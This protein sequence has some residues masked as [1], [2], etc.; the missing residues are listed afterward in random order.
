MKQVELSRLHHYPERGF[1]LHRNK[2]LAPV[3]FVFKA[4]QI[5]DV[6]IIELKHQRAIFNNHYGN[7]VL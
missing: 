2:K 6:K 5:F 1:T 4:E 7:P 3:V